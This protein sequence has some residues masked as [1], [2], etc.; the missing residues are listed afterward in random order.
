MRISFP[1]QIVFVDD[2]SSDST[3]KNMILESEKNKELNIKIIKGSGEGKSRAVDLGVRNSDGHYCA[4]LDA[5][6]TGKMEDLNLFYSAISIGNGDLINGSRLIYRPQRRSMKLINYF[7]NHFFAKL[8][9]HITSTKITDTLCGTKCFKKSDWEVELGVIIGK[10][11]KNISKE[12]NDLSKQLNKA[13]TKAKLNI[14][15]TIKEKSNNIYNWF[16][17]LFYSSYF[18]FNS[19]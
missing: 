8:V 19:P 13:R 1:Y 15:E 18:S 7:G 16:L 3:N 17:N 6:L 11:A 12:N 14:L 5:D 10:K 2:R 9:T 4:I